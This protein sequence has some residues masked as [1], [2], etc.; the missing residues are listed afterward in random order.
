MPDFTSIREFGWGIKSSAYS[1]GSTWKWP[2]FTPPEIRM[3]RWSSA[4]STSATEHL[5]RISAVCST[6][7][8]RSWKAFPNWFQQRHILR[9]SPQLS[10]WRSRLL[11][12]K[13][14]SRNF[15]KLF[16]WTTG[17][18]W[19]DSWNFT[20]PSVS[21]EWTQTVLASDSLPCLGMYFED[22]SSHRG[23]HFPLLH[24]ATFIALFKIQ[25]SNSSIKHSHLR[26][27]VT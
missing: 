10:G 2:Q 7:L 3:R 17:K 9:Q 19:D 22:F 23:V 4:K 12:S 26:L 6:M 18:L 11:A 13:T 20:Q 14:T 21:D 8:T 27:R 25:D 24:C 15:S 1:Q 16:S 5:T